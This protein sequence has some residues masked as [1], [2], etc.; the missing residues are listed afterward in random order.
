MARGPCPNSG[1]EDQKWI[2]S[3]STMEKESK[4][5]INSKIFTFIKIQLILDRG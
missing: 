3:N 2:V 5:P 1:A 4:H